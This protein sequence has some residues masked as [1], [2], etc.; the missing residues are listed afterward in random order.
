MNKIVIGLITAVVIAVGGYFGFT[1]Y[2]QHRAAT[3]VEAAFEAIRN[4][5]NKATHGPVS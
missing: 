4:L 1:F 2:A 3:E 5:G